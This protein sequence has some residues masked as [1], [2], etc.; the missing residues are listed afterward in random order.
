VVGNF[1]D[2]PLCFGNVEK[3]KWSGCMFVIIDAG[4]VFLK[5]TWYE[6]LN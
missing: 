6:K 2:I 1:R 3:M 5:K 4:V